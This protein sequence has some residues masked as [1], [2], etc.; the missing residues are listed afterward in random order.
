MTSAPPRRAS[1]TE[2]TSA[3]LLPRWEMAITASPARSSEA[4]MLWMAG[5][6]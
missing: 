1:L 6:A 4:A 5:S 2:R 3:G